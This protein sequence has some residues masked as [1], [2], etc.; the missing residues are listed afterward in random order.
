MTATAYSGP[1]PHRDPSRYA[2]STHF[3]QACKYR[4]APR[5]TFDIAAE[6]IRRGDVKPAHRDTQVLFE[7]DAGV[8]TWRVVA[9]LNPTAYDDPE[10]T[11]SLVTIYAK[12]AHGHKHHG[13][14]WD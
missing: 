13:S 2:P 5:P 3:K 4:R 9:E 14:V 7:W 8:T 6:T 12:D 10:A 11:H 1:E